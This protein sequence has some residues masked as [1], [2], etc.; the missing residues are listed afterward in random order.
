MPILPNCLALWGEQ[1]W[2][3]IRKIQQCHQECQ[4]CQAHLVG[5]LGSWLPISDTLV[6][7]WHSWKLASHFSMAGNCPLT[8]SGAQEACGTRGPFAPVRSCG[9]ERTR[10]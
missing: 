10:P 8:W 3:K 2:K 5:T 1:S 7:G 6:T 4:Q 9:L